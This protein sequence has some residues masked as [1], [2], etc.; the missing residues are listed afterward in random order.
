MAIGLIDL[1]DFP[2]VNNTFGHAA[3]DASIRDTLD[4]DLP[5]LL[6]RL[7]GAVKEPF[8]VDGQQ[9]RIDMSMG[10]ALVP[11]DGTGSRS[12]PLGADEALDWAKGRATATATRWETA[13][14]SGSPPVDGGNA[15]MKPVRRAHDVP[16]LLVPLRSSVSVFCCPGLPSLSSTLSTLIDGA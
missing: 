8:E 14:P 2:L 11:Q 15:G 1:D 9:V 4:E 7:H 16:T 6:D 3:G 5:K 13:D 10:I 12:N